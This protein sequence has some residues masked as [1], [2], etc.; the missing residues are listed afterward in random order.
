MFLP[1]SILSP[2][3]PPPGHPRTRGGGAAGGTSDIFMNMAEEI[4]RNAFKE[5]DHKGVSEDTGEKCKLN[6]THNHVHSH[7][8]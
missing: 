7:K 3:L 1:A 8:E 2:W 4:F 6:G 5:E